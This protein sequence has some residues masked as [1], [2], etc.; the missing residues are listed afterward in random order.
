MRQ[1]LGRLKS[2]KRINALFNKGVVLKQF[3]LLL[4]Y[5]HS[6]EWES[7][8]SVSKRL[9]KRAVDRNRIKRLLREA[10]RKQW[11]GLSGDGGMP[12]AFMLLFVG[13]SIPSSEEITKASN[14]LFSKLMI[15]SKKNV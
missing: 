2:E 14:H 15:N 12:C 9:F 4:F 7:G 3:P 1:K 6:A 8:V 13:R 5:N 10:V 11:Q